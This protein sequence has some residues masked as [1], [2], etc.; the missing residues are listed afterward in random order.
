MTLHSYIILLYLYQKT[1]KRNKKNFGHFAECISQN[2]RQSGL[3][4]VSRKPF[5]RVLKAGTRQRLDSLPSA[6]HRHS[7]NRQG[8]AECQP[9]ALG[10]TATWGDF[11]RGLCRVPRRDTRHSF[12]F[13]RVSAVRHSAKPSATVA[14]RISF[15]ECRGSRQRVC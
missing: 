4:R 8:F 13:C 3:H 10:K 6:N 2:T 12:E 1:E 14:P 5:C 7:A 9:L 15:A 11:C